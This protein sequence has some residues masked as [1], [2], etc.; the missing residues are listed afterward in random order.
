MH[1]RSQWDQG[2]IK[3]AGILELSK[4]AK[5]PIVGLDLSRFLF[6]IPVVRGFSTVGLLL[7]MGWSGR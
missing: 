6:A 7:T 3:L 1:P 4:L 2:G 5:I